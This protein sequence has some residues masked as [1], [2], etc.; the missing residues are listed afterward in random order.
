MAAEKKTAEPCGGDAMQANI[1]TPTPVASNRA[2]P[3]LGEMKL[4]GSNWTVRGAS[5]ARSHTG[6]HLIQPNVML[7]AGVGLLEHV[8]PAMILVTH[9]HWDHV[10][11]LCSILRGNKDPPVILAPVEVI[12]RLWTLTRAS[13]TCKIPSADVALSIGAP[14]VTGFNAIWG[15]VRNVISRWWTPAHA[16]QTTKIPSDDELSIAAPPELR[17]PGVEVK[18]YNATWV[19]VT[20]GSRYVLQRK[21]NPLVVGVVGLD[22]AS[23]SC[24]YLLSEQRNQ[25]MAQ[26]RDTTPAEKAALR[27]KGESIMEMIE[28]PLLAFICDTSNKPFENEK[29]RARIMRFPSVMMECTFIPSK[30]ADEAE[31]R[32]HLCWGAHVR[33]LAVSHPSVTFVLFHFSQR[34]L[35]KA[36]IL[37]AFE[38]EELPPN[39]R[40]WTR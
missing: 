22:H 37:A 38:G 33:K 12:S 16:S 28:K 32:T 21:D 24:G 30:H 3:V 27:A 23:P 9:S 1:I 8:C 13:Q 31:K 36:L 15:A 26:Y 39:V 19:A 20:D 14:P 11:A 6:F 25:L 18:G 29:T 5:M 4:P 34:Y 40:L 17:T 10:N 7:D 2:L 35:D